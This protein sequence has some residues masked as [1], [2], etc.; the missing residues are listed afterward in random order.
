VDESIAVLCFTALPGECS[1]FAQH[2]RRALVSTLHEVEGSSGRRQQA[3]IH[4]N[5]ATCC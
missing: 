5:I 2:P 1:S 4:R 3:I